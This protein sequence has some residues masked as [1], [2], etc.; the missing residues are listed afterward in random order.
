MREI[1][2]LLFVK[3]GPTMY[4][5]VLVSV[6][7]LAIFLERLWFLQRRRIIPPG[8]SRLLRRLVV[9]GRVNEAQAITA[10][11]A[12]TVAAIVG[13]GVHAYGK[14]REIIKEKMED[15]GSQEIANLERYMN[16]LSTIGGIATLLG[17]FGTV[18]GMINV[19][20]RVSESVGL[21][22][23]ER[24]RLLSSGIYEVLINTAGGLFVAICAIIA[25][26]YLANRI[27][28][29][30]VDL[31]AETKEFVDLLEGGPDGEP[32]LAAAA[33]APAAAIDTKKR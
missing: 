5:T 18:L 26:T 28:G 13:A 21:D 23:E 17:L 27:N 2:D 30:V 4:A 6:I 3:G 16:T 12:S 15:A 33:L 24:T 9:E 25:H 11:N 8:F 10:E 22:L 29:L 19:F 7:A 32:A 14:P 1:Y 20:Q 31:E